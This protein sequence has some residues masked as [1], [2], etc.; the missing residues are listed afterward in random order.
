M[1]EL[2]FEETVYKYRSIKKKKERRA[3]LVTE[4]MPKLSNSYNP[5]L[6]EACYDLSFPIIFFCSLN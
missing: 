3:A 6:R 4:K 5:P 1:K 2:S